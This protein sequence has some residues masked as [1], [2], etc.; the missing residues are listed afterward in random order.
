MFEYWV[1]EFLRKEKSFLLGNCGPTLVCLGSDIRASICNQAT[2]LIT[3]P[4]VAT[5][6][7]TLQ[8]LL[9]ALLNIRLRGLVLCLEANI[10]VQD[11][12]PALK[13][14]TSC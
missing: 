9:E 7:Y 11:C 8:G 3:P 4:Y 2:G 14:P 6:K 10:I 1:V 13:L 5:C 12:A